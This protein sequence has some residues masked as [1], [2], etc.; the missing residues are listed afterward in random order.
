M[1]RR[2][3]VIVLG[4]SIVALP[5]SADAQPARRVVRIGVLFVSGTTADVTGPDVPGGPPA[6]CQMQDGKWLVSATSIGSL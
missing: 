4:G 2:Y 1:N 6:Q 5:L 3:F